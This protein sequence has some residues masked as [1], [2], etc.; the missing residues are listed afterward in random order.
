LR[1]IAGRG[2]IPTVVAW[3]EFA[4]RS[5]DLAAEGR[6]LLYQFGVGLAFLGTVASDG[7]PRVHPVCPLVTDDGL[8]ALVIVSP[9]RDDLHRDGRYALH[10][11]PRDD[12]E[13]AFYVTGVAHLEADPR[14]E[15]AARDAFRAE[16]PGMELS[17]FAA[18]EVF[19]FD[20]ERVMLTRT[21]GHG[22]PSPRHTVW[23]AS[24]RPTDSRLPPEAS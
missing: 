6:E 18:Q 20:V 10:S 1:R 11:F 16:R 5:P 12:D 17:D 15:T 2:T 13:D 23:R 7:S 24:D 21:T 4:R 8:F 9:K 22:D 19:A 3:P 14:V